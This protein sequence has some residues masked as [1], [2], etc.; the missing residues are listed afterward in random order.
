MTGSAD[1][2]YVTAEVA[3]L[4]GMASDWEEACD[5][6]DR[7]EIRRFCHATMDTNPAYHNQV[8][9]ANARFGGPVAPIAMPV[10][11]FRR[12]IDDPDD[13]LSAMTNPDFDGVSRAR[14]LGLP[15]VPVPLRGLLNG[16][17]AYEFFSHARAGER[18]KRRSRYLD[19]Y[20]RAGKAG[21]LVFVV[22]EDEYATVDGRPLF[23]V[24]NTTIMR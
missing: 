5:S 17:Y 1:T 23:N 21:P 6:I 19:I 9:H 11:S 13:P 8:S 3:A 15:K 18:I 2:N 22:I 24:A 16:G 12:S 7:S 4:V 10:H 14:R 20:Q